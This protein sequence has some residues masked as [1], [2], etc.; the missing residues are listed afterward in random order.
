[1]ACSGD[2][3]RDQQQRLAQPGARGDGDGAD[4]RA[5]AVGPRQPAAAAAAR[6]A[7]AGR[8]LRQGGRGVGVRPA[9]DGGGGGGR[10]HLFSLCSH[11]AARTRDVCLM[12]P[13]LPACPAGW[14][15]ALGRESR[16]PGCIAEHGACLELLLCV[17]Q[18][19]RVSALLPDVTLKCSSR[20]ALP[21]R[22]CASP[23]AVCCRDGRPA[24]AL[25]P[26]RVSQAPAAPGCPCRRRRGRSCCR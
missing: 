5:G 14:H 22:T 10:Q 6:H 23:V 1:M 25:L 16:A 2:G 9:G 18:H 4:G 11:S 8:R 7:G 3:G 21:C 19:G 26:A 17:E 20:R 15:G 12:S 13:T 24:C